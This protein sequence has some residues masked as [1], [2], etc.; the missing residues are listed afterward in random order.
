MWVERTEVGKEVHTYLYTIHH[1]TV[2]DV[3]GV[4]DKHKDG[5]LEDGLA[6]VAK[7]E[8]DEQ[9][10]RGE[11]EQELRGGDTQ[12]EQPDDDDQDGYQAVD[13]PVQ[14]VHCRFGVV[15]RQRQGSPFSVHVDLQ[16]S[17]GGWLVSYH[18]HV[19]T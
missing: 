16:G 14:L 12:H 15:E 13:D 9:E 6:C 17:E 4:H 10:L 11:E 5:G 8:D 2:P 19:C 1:T 18:A 7:H 3:E